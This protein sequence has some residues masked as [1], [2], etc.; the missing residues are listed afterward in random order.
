M[1]AASCHR[2]S[3]IYLNNKNDVVTARFSR[4]MLVVSRFQPLTELFYILDTRESARRNYCM[5]IG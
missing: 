5:M 4:C 3:S 1:E 2:L